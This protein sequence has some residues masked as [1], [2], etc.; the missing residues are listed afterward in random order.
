MTQKEYAK[1]LFASKNKKIEDFIDI[2]MK[3]DEFINFISELKTNEKGYVNFTMAAQ[4][5]DPSKYSVWVNN[6]TPNKQTAAKPQ[7][8]TSEAYDNDLPF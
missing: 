8:A 3:K 5:A 4:K 6:W 1:G 7:V 2:S